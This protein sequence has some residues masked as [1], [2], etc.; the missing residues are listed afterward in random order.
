M[1]TS[2]WLAGE[3]WEWREC[4]IC[5]IRDIRRE[6]WPLHLLYQICSKEHQ[7]A[8]SRGSQ[9]RQP[10]T[11]VGEQAQPWMPD[12]IS[13]LSTSHLRGYE[14]TCQ[15]R[16]E[17]FRTTMGEAWVTS[18]ASSVTLHPHH[19]HPPPSSRYLN[20]NAITHTDTGMHACTTLILCPGYS[21]LLEYSSFF[22]CL[23]KSYS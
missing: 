7:S 4:L 9:E 14:G 2:P 6:S 20:L 5:Y 10:T 3:C 11:G 17:R 16:L 12:E 21:L 15:E 1:P 18:S 13:V 22:L 23:V 8:T 19:H